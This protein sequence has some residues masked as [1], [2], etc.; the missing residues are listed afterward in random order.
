MTASILRQLLALYFAIIYGWQLSSSEK[1]L[2]GKK[3]HPYISR[4]L[5]IYISFFLFFY[6]LFFSFFLQIPIYL[7]GYAKRKLYCE[8]AT[9][10]LARK[11]LNTML[12]INFENLNSI[13]YIFQK[14]RIFSFSRPSNYMYLFKNHRQTFF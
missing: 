3:I 11:H 12:L 7:V 9:V 8:Q 14:T 4:V 1:L 5:Q 13:L 6:F 2:A 10:L